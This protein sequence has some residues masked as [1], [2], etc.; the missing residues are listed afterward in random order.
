MDPFQSAYRAFHSTET[1]LIK[2]QNDIMTE[3]DSKRV[4]LLTLLDLSAAFDTV[5]H[6]TLI[7]RL[8]TRFAVSNTALQ[9]FISYLRD[10]NSQVNVSEIKTWMSSNCL[11]LNE[12]KTEFF[13]A[14]SPYSCHRLNSLL[15]LLKSS[16]LKLFATLASCSIPQ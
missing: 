4:V 6:N 13:V 9:W 16:H 8:E 3:I 11:K 7:R 5:D 2:V 14:G 10:W 15:A 12:S 1:A